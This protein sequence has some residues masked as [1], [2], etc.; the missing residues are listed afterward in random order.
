M[1]RIDRVTVEGPVTADLD[2]NSGV[3]HKAV[4]SRQALDERRRL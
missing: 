2:E 1:N 3:G 4:D